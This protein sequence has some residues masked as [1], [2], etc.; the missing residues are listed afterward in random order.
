VARIMSAL[1]TDNRMDLFGQQV[2]QFALAFIAP[3]GT[4]DY[5]IFS[6]VYSKPY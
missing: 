5:D 4:Y 3:L 2:N 1:K 6:H